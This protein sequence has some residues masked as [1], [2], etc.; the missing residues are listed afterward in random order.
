MATMDLEVKKENLIRDTLNVDN[1]P[2]MKCDFGN[3]YRNF[4]LND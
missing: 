1:S 2:P 4:R 3:N